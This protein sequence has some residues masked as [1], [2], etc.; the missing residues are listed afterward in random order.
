MYHLLSPVQ[1][2]GLAR[3]L[4]LWILWF[5][6]PVKREGRAVDSSLR[7]VSALSGVKF[8]SQVPSSSVYSFLTLNWSVLVGAP[9]TS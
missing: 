4:V 1:S 6:W 5:I 9:T 2:R 7:L 8:N 3:A